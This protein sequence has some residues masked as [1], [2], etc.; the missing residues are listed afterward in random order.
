MPLLIA[1]AVWTL[2][3]PAAPAAGSQVRLVG[4]GAPVRD[5]GLGLALEELRAALRQRGFVLLEGQTGPGRRIVLRGTGAFRQSDTAEAQSFRI[6]PEGEG[7]AVSSTG[8]GLVYGVYRLADIVRRDGLDW[9]LRVSESP[10]FAERMFSYEGTLWNLPDEGF[11]FRD[12]P[13]VNAMVVQRELERSKAAMREL[14][15][16]SFNRVTFLNLN[17][18]DYVNYDRLGSGFEVYPPDSLHRQRTRVFR[19]ALNELADYAHAL[20]M[21]FYLQVYEFSYPDHLD[22]RRITDDSET[23]WDFVR[24]RYDE[25]LQETRLDGVV[26]TATEPSPRL[27]YRGFILWRTP[28]GAGRMASRFHDAIVRRNGRKMVFRTWRVANDMETFERVLAAAPEPGLMFDAKNTDG[29]F[30]L[31]VGENRVIAGG[32]PKKRPFMATFDTFR[33]FDGWGSTVFFPRFWQERFRSAKRNGAIAVDAWGPWVPGCIYPGIWVGKYDSYDYLRHG[34]SPSRAMLYAFARLAWN[35]DADGMAA[36]SEWLRAHLGGEAFKAAE[37]FGISEALWKTTYLTG[38]PYSQI[39]FKWT[40]LFLP[41]PD[42]IRKMGA[43]WTPEILERS[44][45]EAVRLAGRIRGLMSGVDPG[46]APVPQ[47][48]ED[49]KRSAELTFTYFQTFTRWRELLYRHYG[50]DAAARD[51]ERIRALIAELEQI[52]PEWRKYPR[53]AKDWLIFRFDPDLMT[54]PSWMARTSV[55]ET[56]GEIKR[57]YPAGRENGGGPAGQ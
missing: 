26:V 22:G 1:A 15:R 33:E 42:L 34:H 5:A 23:T 43:T 38:H 16:H 32:A 18:E 17:L 53:E 6:A 27:N 7:L 2:L 36:A 20:H 3:G 13:Y 37:A 54:A 56:I 48:A 41:R 8:V 28:E 24:A 39:A 31:N 4:E 29:D 12:P 46:K 51:P 55:A 21:Q 10:A 44:N 49:L 14:A 57:S 35:P 45:A 25:L 19:E 40:M 50:P 11:Y 30:F 52:L 47:A 9:Q